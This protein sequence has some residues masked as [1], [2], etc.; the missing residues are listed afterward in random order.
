MH[1]LGKFLVD[2][3]GEGFGVDGLYKLGEM[4]DVIYPVEGGMEDWAYGGSWHNE[5]TY[6][7]P[8]TYK[9]YPKGKQLTTMKHCARYYIS[10]KHRII[11]YQM[12]TPLGRGIN[13]PHSRILE[14]QRK[15]N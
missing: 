14:N 3:S 9:G 4:N 5:K 7:R 8:N 13:A 12:R 6:C 15:P 2:I 1:G 10:S 11:K